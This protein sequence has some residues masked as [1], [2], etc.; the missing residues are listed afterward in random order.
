LTKWGVGK[1]GLEGY[2]WNSKFG[3]NPP[4]SKVKE[5]KRPQKKEVSGNS[6]LALIGRFLRKNLIS[7]RKVIGL[8]F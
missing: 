1:K 4:G 7:L 6:Y 2:Y 3:L 8:D 5:G